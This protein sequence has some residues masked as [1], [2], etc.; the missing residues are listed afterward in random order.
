LENLIEVAQV[1]GA[2]TTFLDALLF[3]WLSTVSRI[4]PGIKWWAGGLVISLVGFSI[5]TLPHI[6]ITNIDVSEH[7]YSLSE[8]LFSFSMVIGTR[9]F[10]GLSVHKALFAYVL[11]ASVLVALT[12]DLVLD[13]FLGYF[14]TIAFFNGALII[15]TGYCI[16]RFKTL[17]TGYWARAVGIVFMIWGIHWLDAPLMMQWDAAFDYGFLFALFISNVAVLG[18][19]ALMLRSLVQRIVA[20][21]EMAVELSMRD[22][23]TMLWNRRYLDKTFGNFSHN[24]KRHNHRMAI[25]YIDLDHFKP[26]NDTYGHDV[27]DEVLCQVS[28]RIVEV[29]RTSDVAVRNGG[30]EF[31]VLIPHLEDD[32]DVMPQAARL[33]ERICRPYH[34]DS[35]EDVHV[36]ASIGVA[37]YPDHAQELGMLLECADKAMY[38]VKK[39]GRGTE[40]QFFST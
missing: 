18:Y 19:A 11:A 28:Q 24:A 12:F 16:F 20:A 29:C 2:S 33:R 27:G 38:Q 3:V 30:D 22:S 40:I 31:V 21:E 37:I 10:A 8:L 36:G 7:L 26:V 35:I 17:E 32:E 23:L 39:T 25:I 1:I 5:Y 34:I 13:Q 14:T 15:H 6:V 9:R 4:S